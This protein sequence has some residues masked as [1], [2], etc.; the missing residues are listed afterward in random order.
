MVSPPPKHP[1]PDPLDSELFDMAR[2]EERGC[3]RFPPPPPLM[4]RAELAK[5]TP[6]AL[7]RC[8]KP[9]DA[10]QVAARASIWI[11]LVIVVLS[12]WTFLK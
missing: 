6:E 9:L 8:R 1:P 2:A 4:A 5:V 3:V 10:I 7:A 12:L 11:A